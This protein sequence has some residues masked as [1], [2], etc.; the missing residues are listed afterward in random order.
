M[1]SSLSLR[2]FATSRL[3]C[4]TAL[5]AWLLMTISLPAAS[6]DAMT[7]Q[8]PVV[9][10]MAAMTMDHAMHADTMTMGGNHVGHCCGDATHP[11]CHCAAMC[12]AV[13][14][15]AVPAW[16]G[17]MQLAAVH[18]SIRGV[19]APTPNPIPPLRPPVV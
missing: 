16:H 11:A 13:L 3:L 5:L 10:G 9:L 1:S 7:G 17:P 14:L 2:R 19:A 6:F 8:D 12:G 4:V 15:P 18:L